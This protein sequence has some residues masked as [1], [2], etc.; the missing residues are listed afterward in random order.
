MR[1]RSTGVISYSSERIGLIFSVPPSHACA[2]PM[3]PP[4][5]QV[6]ERVEAEPDLQRLARLAH[7]RD[8]R[9][10]VGARARRG[11]GGEHEQTGAAAAA[12][13]VEHLDA[14]SETAL[15]EQRVRLPRG[16]DGSGDPAGE[17]DRDDVV[18]GL[19]QRLPDGEEVADRR[20]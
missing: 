13:G 12:F 6:L 5:S 16:L 15:A 19:E 3:R 8:Y 2:L 11:A 20:L 10:T 17:V 14:V 1:T 7:V 9:V 4:R 18:A